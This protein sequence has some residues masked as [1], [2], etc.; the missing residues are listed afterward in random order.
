MIGRIIVGVIAALIGFSLVWKTEWYNVNFGSIA[1]AEEKFG[2]NGGS[3]LMYKMIGIFIIFIGFLAITDM[4]KK[5]L[6][7]TVG[8]LFGVQQ[9]QEEVIYDED[10]R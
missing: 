5:F 3:R 10:T 2:T 4:H 1:W 6:N 8:R 7:A 9:P